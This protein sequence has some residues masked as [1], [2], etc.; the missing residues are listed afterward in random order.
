MRQGEDGVIVRAVQYFG[1]LLLQPACAG[2]RIAQWAVAVFAGVVMGLFDMPVGA[3]LK[4]ATQGRGAAAYE[5]GY[6]L[7]FE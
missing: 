6:G 5:G 4:V 1:L 7:E 3:A 2:Q